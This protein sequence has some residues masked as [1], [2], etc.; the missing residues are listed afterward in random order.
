MVAAPQPLT[1]PQTPLG[2]GIYPASEAARLVELEPQRLRRWVAGYTFRG[3]TGKPRASK[4]LFQNDARREGS[5]LVLSFLDLIETCF[6][7]VFLDHGVTLATIRTVA[8]HAEQIFSRTH[9]FCIKRFETDGE[10]I[11]ARL[12]E[13]GRTGEHLLDLKRRHFVFPVVFNPLL[14][15]LDY[16]SSGDATRW[17]PR[18]RS[19]PIVL[20]PK[21]AFGAAIVARS[22]VPT[23]TLFDAHRSGETPESIARWFR[24]DLDE[25]QAAIAFETSLHPSARLAR[26]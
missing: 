4:P 24:V 13:P 18:G 3:H 1:D 9:P 12:D 16:D 21:R 6:V 14:K 8:E 10:T 5:H 2:R 26:A 7:K 22:F 11:L 17:W 23:R 25:V 15:A 19:T 20:D